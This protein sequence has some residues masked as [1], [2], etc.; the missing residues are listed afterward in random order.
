MNYNKVM[1]AGNL[2]RDVETRDVNGKTVVNF[3]LA[4]NHKYRTRDGEQRDETTFVDCEAWGKVADTLAEHV[5]KGDPLFIEGRLKLDQWQDNNGNNRSKLKAVVSSFQFVGGKG[6]NQG[7]SQRS[8][9]LRSS[10]NGAPRQQTFQG[11]GKPNRTRPA[12]TSAAAASGPI[13]EDDIPF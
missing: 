3:G 5:G 13:R 1:L 8:S 12:A 10:G 4:I 7:A 11:A 9:D 6:Q 2:T